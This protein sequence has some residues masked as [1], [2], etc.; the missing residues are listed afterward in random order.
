MN[1]ERLFRPKSIAVYG[2]KWS[3]YV[4][5]QCRKLGFSGEIW[6]VNPTRENCIKSTDNLP[7][8]Y[9]LRQLEKRKLTKALK[10]EYRLSLLISVIQEL[11]LLMVTRM[12]HTGD[13]LITS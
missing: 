11:R 6:H 12:F 13:I 10:S 1:L 3:D 5:Q 7:A 2:G 4:V 9:C 8:V